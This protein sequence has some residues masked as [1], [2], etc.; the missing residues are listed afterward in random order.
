[1]T[2][3]AA[4]QLTRS[5]L[6]AQIGLPFIFGALCRLEACRHGGSNGFAIQSLSV[7]AMHKNKDVRTILACPH[8]HSRDTTYP[9][10][11]VL[12]QTLPLDQVGTVLHS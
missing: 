2:S 9:H 8:M 6:D 3:G 4:S 7:L 12:P 1:M 10:D 5:L 11:L